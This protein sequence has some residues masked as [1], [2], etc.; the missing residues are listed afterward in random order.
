MEKE[1][2]TS[3]TAA[4]ENAKKPPLNK[5]F[6]MIAAPL[7]V[8]TVIFC[9]YIRYGFYPFG[10][11]TVAWADM[12]QQVVPLLC[13]FKDILDGKGGMFLSFKN[14]S[15]M[16]WWGVFFFFL[17]SPF[18][19]LVK[20][21]PKQ[22]I[23]VFMN[24]LVVIKMMC[25]AASA[26]FYFVKSNEHRSLGAAEISLLGFIYAVSGYTML[27]YQNIIWLDVMYLF[28][29]LLLSIENI[30]DKKKGSAVPYTLLMAAVVAVNY[31]LGY[32][33]VIF[34]LLFTAL[35][36]RV[37]IKRG[38]EEKTPACLRF[39]TG[40]LIAAL[41][42]AVV[43]MPSFMQYLTSGRKTSLFDNLRSGDMLTDYETVFT[44]VTCSSALLLLAALD[45]KR[46]PAAQTRLAPKPSDIH[47]QRLC[48]TALML[49]PIIIEPINKMWHTGSYMAFP[50][51]YAFMT[52]FMLMILAA[53]ALGRQRKFTG[54]KMIAAVWTG[55]GLLLAGLFWYLSA[56]YITE[57][58][59]V[60]GVYTT[61]LYGCEESFKGFMR[62]LL[63]ALIAAVSVYLTYKKGLIP[64]KAFVCVLALL[65]A[66]E[67]INNARV[68]M[69]FS[70]IRHED[71]YALQRE[72]LGLSDRVEND[73][74][75]YRV[76]TGGKIF[77]YNMIG[78]MDYNSIGSYT[79]LNDQDYLFTMKRLGYTSVWMEIG[80][81]G[82]TELTDSLLSVGYEIDHE[83]RGKTLY[84]LDAYFLNKTE[85]K[86]PQG[87]CLDSV[88]TEEI[89]EEL[90]REGVQGYISE[91]LF[92]EDITEHYEPAEGGCKR[93]ADGRY[94][95]A[96]NDILVYRIPVNG[97]KTLYLDCFDRLS[98]DLSEPVYETFMVQANGKLVC[99]AYPYSK[100]N[101]VLKLGT[102]ENE[103]VTVQLTVLKNNECRSFGVFS[104][105]LDKLEDNISRAECCDLREIKNGLEG[106]A[107]VSAAKTVLLSVPYNGGFTVRV[108]GEKAEIRKAL[109]GF[110][111]FDIPAGRSEI[112]ITFC[113]KGFGAGAA[114]S[115]IGVGLFIVYCVMKK[116]R[117]ETELTEKQE[118]VN[119]VAAYLTAA[120]GILVFI[121]VYVIP[122]AL[123]IIMW[124]PES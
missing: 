19:L 30:F 32:M 60:L 75:F 107:E 84:S 53:Y 28:P 101:G 7:A 121:G 50:A 4:A 65:T 14:S 109:S 13:Q 17:A 63:I 96:E 104:V 79:S 51:R 43:W 114:T 97:R 93:S 37:L 77:D 59:N 100:D 24:I 69:T 108:N 26:C 16:N 90:S 9:V 25:C 98:T 1:K 6:S 21:V 118:F 61:G 48:M 18:S 39:V 55:E 113:P 47:R 81:C 5:K 122:L 10:T 3:R 106:A 68:Y 74:S 73:D 46:V 115:F 88:P 119:R 124:K 34:V 116:R 15:G 87:V 82:G 44:T 91:T 103:N 36:A 22:D 29:L 67:T 66:F 38:E 105:D 117:A 12:N 45:L 80:T 35:Y 89:P 52:V 92:G 94:S 49:V 110:M 71:T 31:Y 23:L 33:V 70:G 85:H 123:N 54:D 111:A 102:F 56:T 41:M 95:F 27:F 11:R 78:A 62:L 20:F 40:S 72:V 2:T 99:A 86:L 83:P 112:K 57:N 64:K 76:K 42:S 8:L 120:L 58:T